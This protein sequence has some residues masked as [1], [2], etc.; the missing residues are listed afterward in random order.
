MGGSALSPLVAEQ[1]L[2]DFFC[3][4][5]AATFSFLHSSADHYLLEAELLDQFDLDEEANLDILGD[6]GYFGEH[7]DHEIFSVGCTARVVY[8]LHVKLLVTHPEHAHRLLVVAG[9]RHEWNIRQSVVVLDD[10][11]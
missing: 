7:G 1:T 2:L 9:G 3:H 4:D 5:A 10:P 11:L 6:P 8:L